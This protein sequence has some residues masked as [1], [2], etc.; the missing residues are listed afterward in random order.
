MAHGRPWYKRNGSDL[1][2][3]TLSFPSSDHKWAYS[4]IIDMLN[5]RDRPLADD[6]GFICGFTGL[7]KQKWASVRRY[8]LEHEYLAL[9]DGGYISNPRFERERLERVAEHERSVE[10]G[11]AGGLKSAAQREPKNGRSH[12]SSNLVATNRQLLCDLPQTLAEPSNGHE[13]KTNDLFEPP[14]QARARVE[15]RG[16]SREE[17]DSQADAC[18]GS[19]RGEEPPP[20]PR[21]QHFIEI[22]NEVADRIG[23][24]RILELTGSRAQTL[25]ARLAQFTPTDFQ[26]VFAKVERSDFLA[27]RTP[28]WKGCTF[29][30]II[31][32]ANFVKVLEGNFDD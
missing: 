5:D 31:K 4:A 19:G 25:K 21:P 23:R 17:R 22:W 29:D 7:S 11:R 12:K 18:E 28:R 10:A 16:E 32:Q 15:L 9:I 20:K 13:L 30:W 1:V 24:P 3:A 2:M 26:S 14:P 27:G 8:L 6:A